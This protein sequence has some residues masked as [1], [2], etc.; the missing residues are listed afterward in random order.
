MMFCS[1]YRSQS[2]RKVGYNTNMEIVTEEQSSSSLMLAY[3]GGN[4]D[5]FSELYLKHKGPLFRFLIRQG[6]P[7]SRADE[8]FQEIWLKVIKA[9]DNYQQQARFQTWLY[10]I[11]RNHLI[12]DFR[13]Q[14]KKL[15]QEFTNET[16]DIEAVTDIETHIDSERLK[17]QIL[18]LVSTLPFEQRQAFI[19]KHEIGL[20]DE[21]IGQVTGTNSETAKSRVRYAINQLRKHLGGSR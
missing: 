5:A 4:I 19:L 20:N 11:A 14:G 9:K 7:H 16:V 18:N 6:I 2:D 12:D 8:L 1:L 15:D 3:A 13:K 21:D 17:Q 10:R